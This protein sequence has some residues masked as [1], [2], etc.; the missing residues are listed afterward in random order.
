MGIELKVLHLEV[1]LVKHELFDALGV[2]LVQLRDETSSD[3]PV[4]E[5]QPHFLA[6]GKDQL[7]EV[8]QY[9]L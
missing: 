5:S 1:E 9:E 7:V 3:E 8:V 4:L 6:V 2:Y